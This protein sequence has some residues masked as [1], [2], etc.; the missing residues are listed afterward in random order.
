[1]KI[2]IVA[3]FASE[4]SGRARIRIRIRNCIAATAVHSVLHRMEANHGC[5]KL[6]QNSGEDRWRDLQDAIAH[7]LYNEALNPI[8]HHLHWILASFQGLQG[9]VVKAF[10]VQ[11]LEFQSLYKDL[12]ADLPEVSV[13]QGIQ[14]AQQTD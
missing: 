14:Q 10:C 8:E 11:D 4:F 9:L 12:V 6:D 1:M 13:D 2:L 7:V 3:K 5:A